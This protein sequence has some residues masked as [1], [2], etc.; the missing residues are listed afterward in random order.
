[1]SNYKPPDKDSGL[2]YTSRHASHPGKNN[3]RGASRRVWA[4][5]MLLVLSLQTFDQ[6]VMNR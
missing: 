4:K 5:L 3:K 2:E 6:T 1:M